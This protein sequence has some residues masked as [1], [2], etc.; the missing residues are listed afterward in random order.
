[1]LG[2]LNILRG[3]LPPRGVQGAVSQGST[4]NGMREAPA[5]GL[6][7]QR[8]QQPKDESS[9]SKQKLKN[10]SAKHLKACLSC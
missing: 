10:K 7:R 3:A 2:M 1:M 5:Q 9:A 6:P 8:A 4:D